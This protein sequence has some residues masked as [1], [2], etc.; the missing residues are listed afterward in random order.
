ML[1]S[2][3]LCGLVGIVGSSPTSSWAWKYCGL[4]LDELVGFVGI[5]FG[6]YSGIVCAAEITLL[7]YSR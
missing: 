3:H 1:F 6:G 5:S 4:V 7:F 2:T